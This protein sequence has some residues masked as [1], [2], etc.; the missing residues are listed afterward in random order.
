[1]KI[2]YIK[3]KG[4]RKFADEFE[5]DLY[6]VTS[7]TGKNRA[8][9]S[10]IL[11]AIIN[12]MLGTNLTGNE[13]TCLV[14]NNC[15]ASY[16][17]L[18]FTDNRGKKHILV[19]GK[20]RYF[21]KG[22]ILL[23]DGK[24]IKQEELVSFYKEKKLFLSVMNPLYFLSKKPAE[25]KEM[26]DK[27][28]SDIKPKIIFDRLDKDTQNILINKYYNNKEKSFYDLSE[29]EQ[30]EFVNFNMFNICMDIAFNNLSKDEQAKLEATPTDIPVFISELNNNIK[31]AEN[32]ISNLDGKIG[33]AENFANEEIPSKKI[34]EKE[35]ELSLAMQELDF[36]KSNL[37]SVQKDKQKEIVESIQNEI[38]MKEQELKD[39][40]IELMTGKKHYLDIKNSNDSYCPMCNQK[41]ESESKDIT[42][43]KMH[44][45]LVSIFNKKND[46]ETKIKDLKSKYTIEKCKF[47]SY[48]AKENETDKNRM[49]TVKQEIERLE[50]EKHDIDIYN[51]QIDAKEKNKNGAIYDISVFM[52]QKDEQLKLIDNIKDTK[53]IAQKLYIAYIEEK[54]KLAKEYLKDV[55]IKFYS[56]LKTTGEIKDDFIITY[57]NRSLADL[58]RSETI[59]TSLEFANMFNQISRGYFPIFIDDYESCTDYNFIEEYSKNTQLIISKVEKGTNLKIADLN[60]NR[61]TLIK[62]VIK[63]CRT[64]NIYKVAISKKAA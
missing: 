27:Y 16:G 2:N 11:Y 19:R 53:K 9:K 38:S 13:K 51:S 25:Q 61:Y 1:M 7:I 63:G 24:N 37:N 59:A 48:D 42:I 62:P 54:M 14:N 46:L 23:L 20:S 34:F 58:S 50:N 30:T 43:K 45:E 31:D 47:Y 36:L 21:N 64:M 49:E 60:S 57:K 33:Y 17:E 39:L 26:V 4:F 15:E 41:I 12:I 52:K 35:E 32:K 40:E 56:I 55:D 3:T 28:L 8:G 44:D 6:D 22:N 10:N 18:H 5:T 29:E